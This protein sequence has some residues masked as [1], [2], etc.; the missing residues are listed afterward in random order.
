M[1][2]NPASLNPV[3]RKG[4]SHTSRESG[5]SI[6]TKTLA[7]EV[8]Q[9]V[10]PEKKRRTEKNL[11]DD[12][13]S[14]TALLKNLPGMAYRSRLNQELVMDYVS[15]GCYGLTGCSSAELTQNNRLYYNELVFGDDRSFLLDS[16]ESAV[17]ERK[18]FEVVY[19]LI[20]KDGQE[21]WVR[22][23]GQGTFTQEGVLLAIE[24]FIVDITER[25]LSEKR[26]QLQVNRFE[27]L[28]KIDMAI[29]GSFDLRVTLDILLDQVTTQLSVDASLVL[30]YNPCNQTLEYAAG[31]GL[32]SSRLTHSRLR[33]GEGLAGTAALDRRTVYTPDLAASSEG[34]G[35]TSQFKDEKFVTYFGVPLIAKG[36]VKGILEVFHR[37]RLDPDAEWLDFLE[38][39]AGQAAIAIDNATLFYDL[40]RSNIELTLAYDATLEGW[41]KALELRDEGTEG[42][43][44]RVTD[45]TLRL[46][47]SMQVDPDDLAH[48]RR[49]AL[50]HDIGK[51]GIPDEILLKPGPLTEEQWII[52]RRHPV[53]AYKLLSP[54]ASLRPALDIPYCHHEKWDGTGY[55]RGLQGEQIPLSARVFAVVDVWDALL[56]DRPYRQAW[57]RERVFQ[58]ITDQRGKHFDPKV[59]DV[60]LNLV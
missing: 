35:R 33:P 44:Q 3:D 43:T 29:T 23:L 37:S 8:C 9:E 25:Q 58:Y 27:A 20:T 6:H 40:Q 57:P 46:A 54:I 32:R 1:A 30:L 14:L 50:M 34:N 13:S 31:R 45:L 22:E 5:H 11:R 48:I 28:R 55:P 38:A 2:L 47:Q 51:M 16:V 49:G 12:T 59:V 15:E 39:L 41:S 21:K 52:M 56:S 4:L 18:P 17:N 24:G 60:F 26:T 42:H 7:D 10:K 19:R 53:Y 36:Q